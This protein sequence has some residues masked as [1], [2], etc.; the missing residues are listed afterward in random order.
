MVI[1]CV[2]NVKCGWHEE[3]SIKPHAIRPS[4]VSK[5]MRS[6]DLQT[7]EHEGVHVRQQSRGVQ[8]TEAG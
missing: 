6:H 4:M 7:R 1:L 8:V 5:H 2:L 3:V